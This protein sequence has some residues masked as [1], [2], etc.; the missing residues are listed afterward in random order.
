LR[1]SSLRQELNR[2][3]RLPVSRA[4]EILEGLCAAV[5]AAHERRLLHRDIKPENIFL[6]NP[7]K[8]EIV[9][10]LDFGIAKAMVSADK[11]LSAGQT[12]SGILVGTLRYMSPEQLRGE[13]PAESWDLWALAVVAYEMLTGMH[14]FDGPTPMD[15]HSTILAGRRTPLSAHLPEAPPSLQRFFDQALAINVAERPASAL[16]LYSEFRSAG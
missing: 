10:I 12:D 15:I 2:R 11:A 1:G 7:E 8:S 4:K 6:A 5:A 14:P 3:K 13:R 16:E 9:K